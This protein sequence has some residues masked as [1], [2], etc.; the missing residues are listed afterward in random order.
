MSQIAMPC[1]GNN[2]VMAG[3]KGAVSIAIYTRCEEV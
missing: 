2:A 1:A 3:R